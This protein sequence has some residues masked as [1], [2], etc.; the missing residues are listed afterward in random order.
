MVQLL[1]ESEEWGCQGHSGPQVTE[2]VHI[3]EAVSS[4]NLL[5]LRAA[6]LDVLEFQDLLSEPCVLVQMDIT[7]KGY[8]TRQGDIIRHRFPMRRHTHSCTG[9]RVS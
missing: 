7:Y 1:L 4:M 9:L 3:K 5:E 8:V 2:Q 6:R